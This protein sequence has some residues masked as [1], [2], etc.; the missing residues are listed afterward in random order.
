MSAQVLFNPL[1][2]IDRLT[3]GGFSPEQARASA[4]ALETAFSESVATKADVEGS[5]RELSSAIEGVRRELTANIEGARHEL[6]ANIE[7]VR[8]ELSANIE[9]VK[10]EL[11]TSIEGVRH[12]L[13]L[14][15]RDVADLKRELS[16]SES[17]IKLELRGDISESE[18][19]VRLEIAQSKNETLRWMFGF[20]IV[21]IGAIFTMLK[22]VR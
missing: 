12:E 17:R 22:F 16:E 3:R 5:K 13:D 6:S 18:S 20:V 7:G 14:V 4:E 15:K 21:L 8:H 2:Y 19:R 9:G 11:T 10:H 1:A